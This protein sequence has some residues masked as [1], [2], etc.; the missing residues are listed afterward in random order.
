MRIFSL[1][2]SLLLFGCIDRDCPKGID[3]LPMYGY[4]KKCNAQLES[5]KI[6]IEDC[7]RKF[8]SRKTACEHHI[9]RGWQFLNT[10]DLNTAMKRF[11]QAWLLD[12]I[13]NAEVYEGFGCILAQK[14]QYR[15]AIKLFDRSLM[16]DSLNPRVWRYSGM[17]KIS[18]LDYDPKQEYLD[19]AVYCMKKSVEIDPS[20]S[21][22]Y[23][24]LTIAYSMYY[25]QDSARKYLKITDELNPNLINKE[26]RERI[27]SK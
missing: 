20:D 23:H 11:N 24:C 21:E 12:S 6:F 9:E 7:D 5:D 10:G 26:L 2:I 8:E 22:S 4:A 3:L 18:L 17:S 15:D 14:S 1:F 27:T 19:D 16:I 13:N 25:Q